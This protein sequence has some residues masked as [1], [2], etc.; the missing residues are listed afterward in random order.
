MSET[1]LRGDNDRH[2]RIKYCKEY[3]LDQ[4]MTVKKKPET[5]LTLVFEPMPAKQTAIDLLEGYGMNNFKLLGIHDAGKPLKIKPFPYNSNAIS[6]FRKSFF[7]TDSVCIRGRFEEVPDDRIGTIYYTDILAHKDYP[8]AVTVNDDG[9]FERRFKVE[10]PLSNTIS[11]Q[12]TDVPFIVIPGQTVDITIHKNGS[13][14]YTDENGNP[15]PFARL[16]LSQSLSLETY[17]YRLFSA[18]AQSMNFIDYGQKIEQVAD[19]TVRLTDYLAR[20]YSFSQLEYAIAKANALVT[21]AYWFMEY[22]LKKSCS[23]PDSVTLAHIST[24]EN[25]QVLRN[26]IFDDRIALMLY[27]YDTLQ[28]RYSFMTPMTHTRYSI[29]EDGSYKMTEATEEDSL[30]MS[31]DRRI[32]SSEELSVLA[33]VH[34]LNKLQNR[35][36]DCQSYNLLSGQTEDNEKRLYDNYLLAK[37]EL[38]DSFFQVKADRMYQ[39]YLDTR[40]F[41]YKLPQTKAT[42]ILQ[43]I[44]NQFKGKYVFLDF[45]STFCG[46]CRA[47][48]ENTESAREELRKNPEVAFVFITNDYESPEKLYNEYVE[49]HLKNDYTFRLPRADYE[50]LREQ[51]QFSGIPHYETLDKQGN[52]IRF[53][54]RWH[55]I[56]YFNRMLEEIKRRLE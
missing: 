19:N 44:T 31:I 28:N 26:M 2:Y 15:S 52:V 7:T 25:Y 36:E 40:D 4:W 27:K 5:L 53:S 39:H 49:K 41:T 6:G 43:K 33:K 11:F 1:F 20:R 23:Q 37:A 54:G 12:N 22:D 56:E 32:F 50:L 16:L 30:V 24:P 38:T 48:I 29:L 21:A 18:D 42:Q 3:P 55:S 17:N 14:E 51:F 46:P 45:W 10:H 34:L 47:N 35:I 13:M 9:T 8:I